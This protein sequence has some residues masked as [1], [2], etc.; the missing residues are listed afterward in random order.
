MSSSLTSL[1]QTKN[2]PRG[3]GG[4][5][6]VRGGRGGALGGRGGAHTRGRG[7]AAFGDPGAPNGRGR[8]GRSFDRGAGR[9]R[10]GGMDG[11]ARGRGGPPFGGDRGGYVG[12]LPELALYKLPR[13]RNIDEGLL[14]VWPLEMLSRPETEA[15]AADDE[16]DIQNTTYLGSYNWVESDE[17]TIIVPGKYYAQWADRELPFTIAPDEGLRFVDYNSFRMPGSALLPLL[18]AVDEMGKPIEW[19]TVD[20]VADRNSLRKI[21]GWIDHGSEAKDFR[22]NFELAGERTVLLNRWE[23]NARDLAGNGKTFGLGFERETTKAAPECEDGPVHHRVIKYVSYLLSLYARSDDNAY[24]DLFGLNM[25]VRHKVDAYLSTDAE[26]SDTALAS[27]PTPDDLAD[28]LAT[29]NVNPIV[30]SAEPE[31]SHP[32]RNPSQSPLRIIRG[33]S[34][35]P[36]DSIIELTTRSVYYIDQIDWSDVYPQLYFSQTLHFYLGV[37]TRGAFSEIRKSE[38]MSAEMEA[39]RKA[40]KASLRKFR[41]VLKV[42]QETALAHKDKHLALICKGGELE[43]YECTTEESCLPDDVRRRFVAT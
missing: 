3:R 7:G 1:S 8:G 24:Q 40:M 26:K 16:V 41:D 32:Q 39:Q 35:V 12:V 29:L 43:V 19:P 38:L 33:G 17:P 28:S 13:D 23:P 31:S 9:G 36:Q 6:T 5:L 42:I 18:L 2:S 14:T 11:P 34:E 4:S 25:V 10:S 21:M 27:A 15:A 22:I 37:H 20:F 30:V